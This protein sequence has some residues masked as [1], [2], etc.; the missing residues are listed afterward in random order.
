MAAQAA[1]AAQAVQ[2]QQQLMQKMMQ[3]MS[4]LPHP[5]ANPLIAQQLLKEQQSSSSP[6]GIG[7]HGNQNGDLPG[8][9]LNMLLKQQQLQVCI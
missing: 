9:E 4:I 8:S 5:N 3:N 1:V 6:T 2:H 7:V